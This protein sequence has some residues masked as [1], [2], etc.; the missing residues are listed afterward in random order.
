[1]RKKKC[2]GFHAI[3]WKA[4]A[5]GDGKIYDGSCSTTTERQWAADIG[6]SV[7]RPKRADK[8]APYTQKYHV[9]QLAQ[10]QVKPLQ[11]RNEK[12]FPKT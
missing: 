4:A 11:W 8:E 5:I 7:H 1:M 12:V 2:E 3:G 6:V 10:P 9:D